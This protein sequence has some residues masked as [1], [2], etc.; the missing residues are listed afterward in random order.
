MIWCKQSIC[1]MYLV[2][3]LSH[4]LNL[5]MILIHS[6][7]NHK[8]R[9]KTQMRFIEKNE[10]AMILIII[11][12]TEHTSFNFQQKCWNNHF[13]ESSWF[14]IVENQIL[15]RTRR[16]KNSSLKINLC[17]YFVVETWN[18]KQMSRNVD[19][20]LFEIFANL[21]KNLLDENETEFLKVEKWIW[22]QDHFLSV[23]HLL[24]QI[25]ESENF[26]NRILFELALLKHLISLE[27]E[28]KIVFFW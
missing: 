22:F 4:C 28:K 21:F 3:I 25:F 10:F 2:T 9:A 12:E 18:T 27:F 19:K 8:K 7:M 13:F 11:F 24:L 26:A 5:D 17:E 1:L 6:E 15:C 14:K 23:N 20:A 16:L